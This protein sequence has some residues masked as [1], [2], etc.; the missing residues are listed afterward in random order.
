MELGLIMGFGIILITAVWF[1]IDQY[2]V[3]K[4]RKGK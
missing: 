3:K 1:G 4:S 2:R